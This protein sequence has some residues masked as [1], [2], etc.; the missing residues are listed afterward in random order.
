MAGKKWNEDAKR[1]WGEKQRRRNE[2]LKAGVDPGRSGGADPGDGGGAGDDGGDGNGVRRRDTAH[3]G[4]NLLGTTS[5]KIP[6]EKPE[7][8]P[9]L[10]LPAIKPALPGYLIEYNELLDDLV[11]GVTGHKWFRRSWFI[12]EL[13]PEKAKAE[14]E[15]LW[16]LIEKLTPEFIKSHP[17]LA[18]L[19][20]IL[21]R[22]FMRLRSKEKPK[23]EADGKSTT[24]KKEAP[25]A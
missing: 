17:Y 11:K 7:D 15:L 3:E 24:E 1:A 23:E 18:A 14:A 8:K 16:P 22:P 20:V 6:G 10:D 12:K 2:A 9:L 21:L 19:L 13:S 5:R 4:R 25:A